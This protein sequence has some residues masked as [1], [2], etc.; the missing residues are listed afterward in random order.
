MSLALARHCRRLR[1]I[2]DVRGHSR[3]LPSVRGP[4]RALIYVHEHTLVTTHPFAAR[5]GDTPLYRLST[6]RAAGVFTLT[7]PLLF[8]LKVFGML[9]FAQVLEKYG[10]DQHASGLTMFAA[11]L[12]AIYNFKVSWSYYMKRVE[13]DHDCS[14]NRKAGSLEIGLRGN[15]LLAVNTVV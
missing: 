5:S 6:R 8:V 10:M 7:W 13:H 15:P 9:E 11:G 2:A 4:S 14:S 3:A 12:L 1:D